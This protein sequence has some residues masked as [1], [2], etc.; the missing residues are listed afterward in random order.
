ML[1]LHRSSPAGNTTF[2]PRTPALAPAFGRAYAAQ[3]LAPQAPQ[4]RAER[5][6]LVAHAEAA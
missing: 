2:T 4:R 3:R 1:S 5:A 6:T